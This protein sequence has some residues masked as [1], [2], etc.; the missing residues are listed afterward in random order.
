[1]DATRTKPT[2]SQ[3]LAREAEAL[4]RR[5]AGVSHA[6]VVCSG[7]GID[8]IHVVAEDHDTAPALAARVRSALLAGLAAP[9]LPAR[10]HVRVTEDAPVAR[11][12]DP[13]PHA[14]PKPRDNGHRI[15]LLDNEAVDRSHGHEPV[16]PTVRP[17]LDVSGPLAGAGP[18]ARSRLVAVDLERRSDGRVL[19][20]VAI[21]FAAHVFSAAALAVDLPGAAAQAAAQATVRALIDAGIPG[22]EL[23]GLREVEIAGRHFVIVA[24]RRVDTS[25]RLR[26]GSA[27]IIGSAERAAAE[28]TV[29]AANELI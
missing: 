14:D 15:H 17:P 28:A 18:T 29:V 6:R 10:I 9:V 4:V 19:C 24:L 7:R 25:R 1:V 2:A 8:A 27:P 13:L 16:G 11:K 26:S 12:I 21:A 5:L 23:N 3:E 22:L 20:R